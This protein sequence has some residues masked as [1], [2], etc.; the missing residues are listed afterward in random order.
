MDDRMI[1]KYL[2]KHYYLEKICQNKFNIED[3]Y[4]KFYDHAERE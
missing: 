1:G 4:V 3:K 2:M